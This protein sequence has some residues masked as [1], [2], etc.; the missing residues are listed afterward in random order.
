MNKKH[1]VTLC[2]FVAAATMLASCKSTPKS[3][4]STAVSEA[5]DLASSKETVAEASSM[6]EEIT[7]EV[8][9]PASSVVSSAVSSKA[10]S[11][12]SA[13]SKAASKT[14][15]SKSTPSQTEPSSYNFYNDQVTQAEAYL[16]VYFDDGSY[17][18][19]N[20]SV[21]TT[22]AAAKAYAESAYTPKY[23]APTNNKANLYFRSQQGSYT[24]AKFTVLNSAGTQQVLTNTAAD[25]S[26]TRIDIPGNGSCWSDNIMIPTGLT[27]I[28]LEV[29]LNGTAKTYYIAWKAQNA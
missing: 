24:A 10:A 21:Y 22:E 11:S 9:A 25:G 29:T 23:K 15:S 1:I 4:S 19:H 28:K 20:F 2:V 6:A 12:K 16:T 26:G 27:T 7:S 17:A 3:V 13:S 8:S 5:A 14:A 18:Q